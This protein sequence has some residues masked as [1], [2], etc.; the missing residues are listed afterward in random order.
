M[1]D[2]ADSPDSYPHAHPT[3]FPP[4]WNLTGE[5]Y[6]ILTSNSKGVNHR[7][8]GVYGQLEAQSDFA[9]EEKSGKFKGGVTMGSGLVLIIRYHTSPV[10]TSLSFI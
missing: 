9:D 4:P 3:Y 8:P 6:L 7:S 5:S 2:S 1:T 10:G